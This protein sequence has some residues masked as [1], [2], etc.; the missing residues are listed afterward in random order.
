MCCRYFCI[1]DP[2][3]P[4]TESRCLV[5]IWKIFV[6]RR[7]KKTLEPDSPLFLSKKTPQQ[8]QPSSV[9]SGVWYRAE[10]M[11]VNTLAQLLPNAC[12]KAGIESR[13]NHGV[14]ATCV[15]RLREANVPDDKIIQVTGHK[16]TRSLSSY[17]KKE[18]RP[19]EHDRC[20]KIVQNIPQ[21]VLRPNTSLPMLSAGPGDAADSAQLVPVQHVPVMH[22][23][24]LSQTQSHTLTNTSHMVSSSERLLSMSGSTFN[25]CNVTI[26]VNNSGTSP[27]KKS[28]RVFPAL[29]ASQ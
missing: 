7:S 1:C 19:Q 21:Q 15:Q 9:N 11:G 25:R 20:L 28:R 6:S 27:P 22:S 8:L 24:A 18:L 12:K 17:D 13:G 29:S 26:N 2:Q 5:E 14:R 3:I 10:P 23:A 16:S 4:G